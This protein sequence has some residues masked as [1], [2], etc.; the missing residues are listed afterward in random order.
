M[1][2]L[3]KPTEPNTDYMREP[4]QPVLTHMTINEDGVTCCH[5]SGGLTKFEHVKLAILCSLI[6]SKYPYGNELE[7]AEHVAHEF[8]GGCN[9]DQ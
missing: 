4:A 5:N 7:R 1:T 9:E 6:E 2:N 8:F 3:T